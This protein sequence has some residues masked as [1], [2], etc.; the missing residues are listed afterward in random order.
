VE[1]CVYGATA[2]VTKGD[3]SIIASSRARFFGS[4]SVF[5]RVRTEFLGLRPV[6]FYGCIS[7]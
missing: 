2:A 3:A 1:L 7:W 6:S 5:E 4:E